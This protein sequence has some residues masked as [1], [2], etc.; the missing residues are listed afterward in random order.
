MEID[1]TLSTV[2][3]ELST[4]DVSSSEDMLLFFVFGMPSPCSAGYKMDIN[5][6]TKGEIGIWMQGSHQWVEN[7]KISGDQS[8]E[9]SF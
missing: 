5:E 7:G 3:V 9:F 2:I 4:V 8:C 6:K 1:P